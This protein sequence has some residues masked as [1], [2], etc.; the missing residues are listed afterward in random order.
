MATRKQVQE[1]LQR[2]K[3]WAQ[4]RGAVLSSFAR[5]DKTN[6]QTKVRVVVPPEVPH[7]A[8]ISIEDLVDTEF[9]EP[10]VDELRVEQKVKQPG[11]GTQEPVKKQTAR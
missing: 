10:D 2:K 9:D 1:A 3:E 5:L 11:D 7:D 6:E 4:S 8:R